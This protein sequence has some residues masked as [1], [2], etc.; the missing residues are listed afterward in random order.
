MSK[1]VIAKK[2]LMQNAKNK[3]HEIT[4]EISSFKKIFNEEIN[5]GLPTFWDG[6]GDLYAQKNYQKHSG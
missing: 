5:H 1:K 3:A 4:L 6:N 2:I